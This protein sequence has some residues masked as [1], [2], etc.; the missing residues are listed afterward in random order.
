MGT[1][2]SPE[3]IIFVLKTA[4]LFTQFDES[5]LNQLINFAT[6]E[7]FKKNARIIQENEPNQ[8]IYIL[9][10]GTVSVYIGDELILKLRRK[11]DIIGEMSVIT[12]S[13]TTASV[14][15]A[16]PVD[17]FTIPSQ[18]IYASD[19]IEIRSLWYK[20][21][22][23]ILAQK[24]SMTNKK[25]IGFQEASAR[26]DQKKQELIQKSMILQ[27]V[28]GSMS[29]GV[30][31]T[32]GKNRVLH[33]ND[34]FVRMT[35]N[36]KIPARI[37]DWPEKIGLFKPDKKNLCP[38][39]E[40]PMIKAEKA[41]LAD[42]EEIY[43][44]NDQMETGIWLHATSSL[45]KTDN[46]KKLTGGVVVFRDY[47]KKKLEEEALIKA[48]E[49]AE[50]TA[51][52]K[53]DFLSIMS[54]ELRT[55]LNGILGMSDL[56]KK[57]PLTQ[58]QAEYIDTINKSGRALLA[59]IRNVLYYNALESGNVSIKKEKLCLKQILDQLIDFHR[60]TARQKQIQIV[61]DICS[62]AQA[63]YLGDE[64]KIIK[65][66][67]NIIDNA[68]KYSNSGT[69]NIVVTV[70][71]QNETSI[72]FL[73]KIKDSG[74]GISSEHTREIF[75][76]F[77][78]ADTSYSRQFEGTGLGLAAAKKTVEILGGTLDV[79]STPGQGSCFD[80]T[81]ILARLDEKKDQTQSIPNLAI[82]SL[83][84]ANYAL[85]N[86]LN[87]LVAE[88][89][90][91]NQL[92]IKKILSHLGYEI[93]IAEDGIQALE[94]C[95]NTDF[96]LVLMDIQMPKMDGLE[97][98][99]QILK[100]GRKKPQIVALTANTTAGIKDACL[101]AGMVDYISKPLDIETLVFALEKLSAR[102]L[103]SNPKN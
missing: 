78:Q 27:S 6:V 15:A 32:D 97:A 44:K 102:L 25:V 53:S 41:I 18:N 91:V 17:L 30:V 33:V 59:K 8:N 88:D 37:K 72:K 7:H 4:R 58:E 19:Q 74:I 46:G 73:V 34:A 65:I 39:E 13:L 55:P 85:R 51:R 101:A 96:D 61:S 49:N 56:L 70:K 71:E 3:K 23:D 48:K 98:A 64:E 84:N 36:I 75:Q 43:L 11:G 38:V 5:Q 86:P 28:L 77:F 63:F 47:T 87:I 40:L 45:L 100:D 90:K 81:L 16:T 94:A 68:V 62:A 1:D 12:Q 31:V 57:T 35:G 99:K 82:Q 69:I 42:A 103:K 22:S 26:L 29:D 50:A 83:I 67:D 10:K 60:E 93:R 76:P 66:A 92:L 95:R 24:L 80:F 89:N 21:F 54:H 52:A 2:Y 9:L 79:E 14:I 20:L